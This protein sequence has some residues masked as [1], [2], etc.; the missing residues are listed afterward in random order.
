MDTFEV[1][2]FIDLFIVGV[3][4]MLHMITCYFT[5]GKI[6]NTITTCEPAGKYVC[7]FST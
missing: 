4:R 2:V 5:A 1:I 3:L 7:C 6:K